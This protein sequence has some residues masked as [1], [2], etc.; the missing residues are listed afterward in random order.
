MP[1]DVRL[2][3]IVAIFKHH[4]WWLHR[5]RGSHHSFTNG[6]LHY[7]APVHHGKV[8]YVYVRQIKKLFGEE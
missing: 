5:I 1:S 3:E 4:G 2:S 6:S 8:K 7:T